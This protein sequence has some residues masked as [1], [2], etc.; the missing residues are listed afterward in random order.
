MVR[1]R[2]VRR[3]WERR[4]AVAANE[5]GWFARELL[6]QLRQTGS[7]SG[8]VAGWSVAASRV[9]ALRAELSALAATSPNDEL[10]SR[11]LE[12]EDAVRRAQAEVAAVSADTAGEWRTSLDAAQALLVAAL[13]PPSAPGHP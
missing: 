1:R 10:R 5:A 9:E 7:S 8:V 11:A 4:L 2:R 12:L 3:A 6:P 13:V